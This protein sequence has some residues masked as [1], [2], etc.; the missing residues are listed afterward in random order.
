MSIYFF[1]MKR[2]IFLLLLFVTLKV[3]FAQP[4]SGTTGLLNTPSA[5]MQR[6]GTFMFGGNYLPEAM[7]PAEFDYNTGNYFLNS[8]FLPFLEVNIRFTLLKIKSI[9]KFNQDRSVALRGR[10]LKESHYLP[11]FVVGVNDIYSLRPKPVNQY[12]SSMY[13]VTSKNLFWSK[14]R[15]EIS[16]GYGFKAFKHNQ[17]TGIFGGMAFSPGC[18]KSLRLMAEYDSKVVNAGGSITLFNHLQIVVF[19]YDLTYLAG[20]LAYKVYL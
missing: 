6:D 4:T 14:N 3:A 1:R 17:I 11:S 8:T 16:V 13:L 15:L 18:F 5:E 12:F 19:A 9:G 10:L 2:I 7:M 20:G